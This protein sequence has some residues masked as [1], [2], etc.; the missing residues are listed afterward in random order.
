MT[1]VR[2]AFS[3]QRN[4]S[5]L[6]FTGYSFSSRPLYKNRYYHSQTPLSGGHPTRLLHHPRYCAIQC[7]PPTILY[8]NTCHTLLAMAISC[9]GQ[10]P[11]APQI[12]P[13]DTQPRSRG[14]GLCC[15]RALAPCAVSVRLHRLAWPHR[16]R[17]SLGRRTVC[18]RTEQRRPPVLERYETKVRM[19]WGSFLIAAAAFKTP[20]RNGYNAQGVNL[21]F[22][23]NQVSLIIR[24]LFLIRRWLRLLLSSRG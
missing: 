4:R 11:P 18:G 14:C 21:T 15:V 3:G 10:A 16:R 2:I 20:M 19:V 9:K 6:A 17:A 12:N 24:A 22:S 5:A 23:R 7:F 13:E 1:R 8:C